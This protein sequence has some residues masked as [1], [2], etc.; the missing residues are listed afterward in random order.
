MTFIYWAGFVGAFAGYGVDYAN[1]TCGGEELPCR[2]FAAALA[3]AIWPAVAALY[4]VHHLYRR[5]RA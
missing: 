2:M 3:A 4:T 5:S 1:R